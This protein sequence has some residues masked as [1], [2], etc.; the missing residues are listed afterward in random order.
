MKY[1]A[2]LFNCVEKSKLKQKRCCVT[3]YSAFGAFDSALAVVLRTSIC[4]IC[5]KKGNRLGWRQRFL[6]TR[7]QSQPLIFIHRV[8]LVAPRGRGVTQWR[9]FHNQHRVQSGVQQTGFKGTS[10]RKTSFAMTLY[11]SLVE[12]SFRLKGQAGKLAVTQQL[13]SCTSKSVASS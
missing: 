9:P 12:L 8:W 5:C 4:N 2:I 3:R 6:G 7:T 10:W 1:Y 13:N 11:A